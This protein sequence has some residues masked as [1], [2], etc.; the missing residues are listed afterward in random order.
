MLS[1]DTLQTI[2]R[3]LSTGN[4]SLDEGADK[5]LQ[6][7][8]FGEIDLYE[9]GMASLSFALGN[10][11]G[12]RLRR[13]D[14]VDAPVRTPRHRAGHHTGGRARRP[15]GGEPPDLV[16]R[17]PGS[18]RGR[19]GHPKLIADL[20]WGSLV[21]AR[22]G[23]LRTGSVIAMRSALARQPIFSHRPHPTG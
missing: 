1:S 3:N 7:F 6:A 15:D 2:V 19:T 5:P 17:T 14:D 11:P 9:P 8:G 12:P 4:L 10:G 16:A 13:S 18:N 20:H 21:H 23:H 22:R